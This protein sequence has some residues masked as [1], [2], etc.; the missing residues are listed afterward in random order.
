MSSIVPNCSFGQIDASQK[1]P[2]GLFI[3]RGNRPEL[4]DFGEEI[5]D[6]VAR[7][8]NLPIVFARDAAIGFGRDDDTLSRSRQL[9]NHPFVGIV[10]L[11]GD[12][13][14]GL[15][16]GQQFVRADQIMRVPAGQAEAD[17]VA[18]GIDQR[19]DFG[20]QSAAG[21]PDRL[22][23]SGLFLAPALC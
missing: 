4:F 19:M 22:V 3:A 2:C 16:V 14:V 1:V 8:I 12:Q 7:L 18:K 6:Q 20:A 5:L 23:F 11:V 15:H 21:P 9:L 17:R 10:S 13:Q